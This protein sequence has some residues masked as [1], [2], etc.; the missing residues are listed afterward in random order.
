[1]AHTR[2]G[3]WDIEEPGYLPEVR[4]AL[5][6]ALEDTSLR[7][8]AEPRLRGEIA[9]NY[10][11]SRHSDE[12]F[13]G[14]RKYPVLPFLTSTGR[15]FWLGIEIRLAQVVTDYDF[16]S[17]SLVLF[18]APEGSSTHQAILR[19]EWE[20][21]SSPPGPHAQP[22]WHIYQ[23]AAE[24]IERIQHW[25]LDESGPHAAGADW[26]PIAPERVASAE[27]QQVRRLHLAM[28][29]RW[30]LPGSDRHYEEP[31]PAKLGS[32]IAGALDYTRGQLQFLSDLL[33]RPAG[34]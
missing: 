7:E 23:T 25:I 1:M 11:S 31:T 18:V 4:A 2:I 14:N 21:G 29:A 22:H 20:R 26:V 16:H 12:A 5:R 34:L 9:I 6:R 33:P 32:W 10:K 3:K 13:L 28:S 15:V 8:A 30:H 19:A 24:H 27:Q 17:A